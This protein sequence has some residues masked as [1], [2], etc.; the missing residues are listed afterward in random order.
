MNRLASRWLS[1]FV[2]LVFLSAGPSLLLGDQEPVAK[3][4]DEETL[5]NA[6]LESD[7]PSLLAFFNA[8]AHADIN[9]DR[10]RV[11]LGQ[12]TSSS[13]RERS[14][15]TAEFL[16]LGPLAVP[17]LRRAANNL[18][19]PD[20]AR[21]AGHC[22]EWLEGSSSTSLPVAAARVLGQ[23]KP[24][25]AAAALLACLPYADSR[26]VLQ[27]MTAA[28]A[29]VALPNGKPDAALLRGLADPMAVRRAAAGVALCRAV[30]PDQAPAVRKLL[31]DPAKEVRLRTALAL[32]EAN[33]PDAIPVLIELL[34]DVPLESRKRIE[35][36]LQNFA[37]EWAP[38]Q[39]FMGEDEIGRKVRRD[40]WASWW[41]NVDGDALLDAMRKRTPT[42]KDREKIRDLLKKLVS[43]DFATRETAT[44]EL[45]ALGRR[46]LP[47]LQEAAKSKDV[48]TARRA[49]QLI[50]RIEQDP[51]HH[52]PLA[53]LRLLGL[54]KPPGSVAALLAYLPFAEDDS[55]SMEVRKSLTTLALR[56]GNLDGEL[57]KA[58]ADISPETRASAAEALINGGGDKG[59]AAVR[60]ALKDDS[61]LVR[62]RVALA[63]A[64][65]RDKDGVPVLIDLLTVLPG[66]HV[67]QVEAVLYQL[68]GD[69][70]P[71]VSLGAEPAEKKK[72]RD[73]W[74][75]WWKVNAGRVD[76]A[77][78]TAN[79][80]LGFTVICDMQMGRVYEVDRAGKERW[81]ITGLSWPNDAV[82]LPNNHVL[83]SEYQANRVT[84]R[85]F[86]GNIVWQKGLGDNPINVQ[87]LR[88]GN[89]FIAT[90]SYVVEVDREGK[91]LYTLRNGQ[92]FNA[93]YR[94][95]NNGAIVCLQNDQCVLMDTTG[96]VVSSFQS[97]YGRMQMAGLDVLSNGHILVTQMRRGKVVE[98]DSSGKALAEVNAPGAR[99]ATGLPNGHILVT[100]QANQRVFE[101]DRAGKVVWE[102]KASG[103]VVRARRR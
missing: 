40:A 18:S 68:A 43:G 46:S 17:T 76:L 45:F 3:A 79:P 10:L 91:E 94:L 24:E 100:S 95:P 61:S 101:V 92:M 33:D 90:D 21:R 70:A 6:G 56:E 62:M 78:L 54:R 52:L 15:A 60:G 22:L 2:A 13:P 32:A 11:L 51:S 81:S 42:A 96:K 35:E 8:R 64:L 82:V 73:A 1:W 16:G 72:C 5:H 12:L 39:N 63:L 69:T 29:A 58:L 97:N 37:G 102:V 93:A 85:D 80:M 25:G 89:T 47:Q 44:R 87:R 49:K 57:V 31:K 19:E 65:A 14:L 4:N 20:V 23:R 53:A 66:E 27:A 83:I 88:N 26:E 34:A 67:G 7:G 71:E 103:P 50:E 86:K 30:M 38:A 77:R 41:R 36:I 48:E 99:S 74:V 75:A 59:R 9:P 55:R 28:L 84:E 98:F